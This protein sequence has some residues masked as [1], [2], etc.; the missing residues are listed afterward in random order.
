M[1]GRSDWDFLW[2]ASWLI[3]IRCVRL[4]VNLL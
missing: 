3:S 2:E 4:L 1:E